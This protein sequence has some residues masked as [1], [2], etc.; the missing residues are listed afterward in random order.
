MVL[1]LAENEFRNLNMFLL[2]FE[3]LDCLLEPLLECIWV[4]V[5]V[6]VL[7]PIVVEG[8]HPNCPWVSYIM[9]ILSF[10]HAKLVD[11][12]H[13][14]FQSWRLALY[15][16]HEVAEVMCAVVSDSGLETFAIQWRCL[17]FE[18]FDDFVADITCQLI[19]A[20]LCLTEG[21]QPIRLNSAFIPC[22]LIKAEMASGVLALIE[23]D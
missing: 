9:S 10:I 23:E 2:E 11:H 16:I 4:F 8:E 6:E 20:V 7:L 18:D 5:V 3:V 21:N 22:F 17:G 1:L 12:L 19:W 13:N 15:G 14:C